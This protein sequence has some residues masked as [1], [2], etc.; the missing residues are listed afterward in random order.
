MPLTFPMNLEVDE[1]LLKRP[2]S[3]GPRDWFPRAPAGRPGLRTD[4][5]SGACLGGA[6]LTASYRDIKA[7]ERR[8]GVLLF[9]S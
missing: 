8:K 1:F 3:L 6:A 7:A 5:I 4:N 9:V 2:K